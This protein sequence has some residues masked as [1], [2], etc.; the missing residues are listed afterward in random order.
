MNLKAL[1]IFLFI[2]CVAREPTSRAAEIFTYVDQNGRRIFT[3]VA[4]HVNI[5]PTTQ[6][7]YNR[8]SAL[9]PKGKG[10]SSYYEQQFSK[11][12]RSKIDLLV[13]KYGLA[14]YRVG[15]DF[16][17]AVIKVE[18]NYNPYA[19][20]NKGARGLM[21]LMPATA[22][23]FGVH[24]IFDPEQNLEGG[25][26][27]LRF[28]LD[29]F[30]GDVNLTLAAYNAGENVVQRLRSIPPYRETRDYVKKVSQILGDSQPIPVYSSSKGV[31][32][33][34]LVNGRLKFTNVDPPVSAVVFDGD[35]LPRTTGIQ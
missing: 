16:V 2:L 9:V 33:V 20:S 28:L 4:P 1:T 19:T 13:E 29:T 17:Q 31:T 32:Y 34:A 10:Q 25:I 18:S 15:S 12:L 14:R 3:N 7:I 24:N 5:P 11:E 6:V 21:Q 23:R 26:Q 8:H 22:K 27:Y 35:N 30:R